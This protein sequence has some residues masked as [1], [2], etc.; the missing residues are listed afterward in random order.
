MTG[1]VGP[2]EV[3]VEVGEA[4]TPPGGVPGRSVAD[5]E[6]VDERQGAPVRGRLDLEVD[7]VPAPR[8]RERAR[9]A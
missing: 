4:D 8:E 7:L 1:R 2:V 9:G 3:P 5:L 6:N